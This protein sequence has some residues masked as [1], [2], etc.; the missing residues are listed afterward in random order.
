M[1]K[2]AS[3]VEYSELELLLSVLP[4]EAN[5]D[6]I[7]SLTVAK[8][9]I[10]SVADVEPVA[11]VTSLVLVVDELLAP[12]ASLVLV[13]DELLA[14]LVSLVLVAD[15]LLALL[16]SLVLVADEL[17]ALLVSLVL[18]ADEL[19]ALL[20][21]LV[22]VVLVVTEEV[23]FL[24]ATDVPPDETPD[25]YTEEL[26]DESFRFTVSALTSVEPNPKTPKD[27]KNKGA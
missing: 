27:R 12:L 7:A 6:E 17:L 19:L 1:T 21:S 24:R 15:E 14:L 3:L 18:V 16:V 13:T 9:F 22:L 2:V 23:V 10:V 4:L 5:D 8:L 25:V 26:V 11:L 20:V